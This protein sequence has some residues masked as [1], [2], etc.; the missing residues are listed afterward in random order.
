M[1]EKREG[2]EEVNDIVQRNLKREKESIE[3]FLSKFE[4]MQLKVWVTFENYL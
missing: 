4:T 3:K 1:R 2:I